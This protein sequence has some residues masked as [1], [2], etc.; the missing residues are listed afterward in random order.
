MTE[1]Y[2]KVIVNILLCNIRKSYPAL[3]SITSFDTLPGNLTKSWWLLCEFAFLALTRDSIVF[4][5]DELVRFY[6]RIGQGYSLLWTTTILQAYSRHW[7]RDVF[8]LPP[9]DIS[10]IPCRFALRETATQL[11]V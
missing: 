2:T 9:L 4:F 3:E 11:S 10:R 5:Q 8:S 7:L 6:P 1:L